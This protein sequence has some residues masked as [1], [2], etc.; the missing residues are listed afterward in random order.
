[1]KTVKVVEVAAKS[2]KVKV[3]VPAKA[4]EKKVTKVYV[5]PEFAADENEAEK[6]IKIDVKK[7][8]AAKEPVEKVKKEKKQKEEKAP[9]EASPFGTTTEIMCKNPNITF[10]DL[11]KEITKA[12][13]DAVA[14]LSAIRT[15]YSQA[16]KIF[17]LLRENKF[18]K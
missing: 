17:S 2:A 9:R 8:K 4:A 15:G 7:V 12:G 18:I 16:R 1:M 6:I 10:D 11:K 5:D 3:E 13:F 14:N